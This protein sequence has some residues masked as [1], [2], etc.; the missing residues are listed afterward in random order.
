MFDGLFD[1]F[2][3][4]QNKD[5][6]KEGNP[7]FAFLNFR[8]Y[9][10]VVDFVAEFSGRRWNL[11]RKKVLYDGAHM[12]PQ[13]ATL[14][15]WHPPLNHPPN[16]LFTQAF[17]TAN[18]TYA[19]KQ[20]R[21]AT[22]PMG[23]KPRKGPGSK[24]TSASTSPT[25][26]DAGSVNSSG[27][28][29]PNHW[30]QQSAA[31]SNSADTTSSYAFE[32]EGVRPQLSHPLHA[33]PQPPPSHLSQQMPPS[34]IPS[35]IPT[36]RDDVTTRTFGMDAQGAS[37]ST[38]GRK[39]DAKFYVEAIRRRSNRCADP[40]TQH[41][42]HRDLSLPT[43]RLSPQLTPPPTHSLSRTHQPNSALFSTQF[44]S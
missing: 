38:F 20:R 24:N 32:S 40:R 34:V 5:M 22:R 19:R 2:Y 18:V 26:S 7:G 14:L 21:P 1:F 42:H 3:L 8:D 37:E 23:F 6:R 28:A 13:V 33:L 16:T 4:P 31:S 30:G 41:L 29:V 9:S 10:T 11:D 35:V 43:Q 27:P 15:H 17:K 36:A 44:N 25:N 12:R 39:E